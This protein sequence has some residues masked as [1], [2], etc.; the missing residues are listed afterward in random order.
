MLPLTSFP[1]LYS[2]VQIFVVGPACLPV[3]PGCPQWLP[4]S[5]FTL[6]GSMFHKS[7]PSRSMP[8]P[9][10]MHHLFLPT[11]R[12]HTGPTLKA[13]KN[14][15]T[16]IMELLQ[17][18]AAI[19]GQL[20]EHVGFPGSSV[21]KILPANSGDAGDLGSIPGWGRFPGG[22]NGNRFQYFCLEKPMDRGA[23]RAT[24]HEVTMS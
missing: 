20:G 19:H 2:P 9:R 12:A 23:W 17:L 5:S 16:A 8:L 7:C 24:V 6:E 18:E 10:D 14:N 4:E 15:T 22:E 3:L 1:K 11:K 21:V 13:I